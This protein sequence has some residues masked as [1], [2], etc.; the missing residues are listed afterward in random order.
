M[1]DST[2]RKRIK[3]TTENTV[4]EL[5]KFILRIRVVLAVLPPAGYKITEGTHTGSKNDRGPGALSWVREA[6]VRGPDSL[7]CICTTLCTVRLLCPGPAS[8]HDLTFTVAVSVGNLP[9]YK[10]KLLLI[11]K[12]NKVPHLNI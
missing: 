5:L 9:L 12:D 3:G 1:L 11:A 10:I 4:A 6:W 8:A 7:S 2:G